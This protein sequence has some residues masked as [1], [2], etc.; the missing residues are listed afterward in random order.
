M[1]TFIAVHHWSASRFLI[2]EAP[3]IL[4]HLSDILVLP[5]VRVM[6]QPDSASEGRFH[7][8]LAAAHLPTLYIYHL[9]LTGSI[10]VTEP[11]GSTATQHSRSP[12]RTAGQNFSTA[13]VFPC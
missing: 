12:S 11:I 10:P 8:L 4:D 5:K 9:K 2:S 3:Y 13:E 6:L 7:E 1:Q